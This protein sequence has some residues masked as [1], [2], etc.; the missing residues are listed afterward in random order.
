MPRRR[1]VT[2]DALERLSQKIAETVDDKE[3]AE[4]ISTLSLSFE[5]KHE[6]A[7]AY[8][9]CKAFKTDMNPRRKANSRLRFASRK[10]RSR[11]DDAFE[12]ARSQKTLRKIAGASPRHAETK[13][14]IKAGSSKANRPHV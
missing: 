4:R 7:G 11:K 14:A 3:A 9:R 10:A 8:R 6:L 2:R 12:A 1:R 13:A 5:R